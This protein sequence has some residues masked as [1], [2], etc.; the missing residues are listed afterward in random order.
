MILRL[1]I[2]P[3]LME[4]HLPLIQP[5]RQWLRNLKENQIPKQ[6]FIPKGRLQQFQ[7]SSQ[8]GSSSLQWRTAVMR[9]RLLQVRKRILQQIQ[10]YLRVQVRKKLEMN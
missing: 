7:N 3:A 4:V 2:L 8:S 10:D 5:F 6:R 1:Q 9:A